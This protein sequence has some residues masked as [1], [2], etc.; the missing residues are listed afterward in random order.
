MLEIEKV[1][2]TDAPARNA[3]YA[4]SQLVLLLSN[5]PES[6][7]KRVQKTVLTLIGL[8]FV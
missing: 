3:D 4:E 7:Q 2:I 8:V 6:I 5:L 1:N